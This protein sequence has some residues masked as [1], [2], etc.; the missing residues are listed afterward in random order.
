MALSPD[1][2]ADVKFLPPTR[3]L[4]DPA[5]GLRCDIRYPVDPPNQAWMV[6]PTF[7]D[8][9]GRPL[10]PMTPVPRHT[11]AHFT[12]LDPELRESVHRPRLSP[13][14]SFQMVV[15]TTPIADCVVTSC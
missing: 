11:T 5:Q 3:F 8:R 1:F 2:A 14:A 15:G 7:V 10:P 12:I 4:K 6:W 13:G 9:D